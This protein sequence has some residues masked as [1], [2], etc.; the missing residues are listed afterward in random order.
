MPF[1]SLIIYYVLTFQL[2]S[3]ESNLND[4]ILARTSN[5][6]CSDNTYERVE[7]EGIHSIINDD[8][9]SE[10]LS[11]GTPSIKS[12]ASN[13]TTN[14]KL[15]CKL[16]TGDKLENL[17]KSGKIPVMQKN[18]V[19]VNL[20]IVTLQE[21][22]KP[23]MIHETLKIKNNFFKTEITQESKSSKMSDDKTKEEIK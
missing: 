20:P 16:D 10:A 2:S 23:E 15:N 14:A 7:G 3:F 17:C 18:S 9:Y 1:V 13:G 4:Q 6:Y 11:F 22:S 12:I 19:T 5:G 8:L 21:T